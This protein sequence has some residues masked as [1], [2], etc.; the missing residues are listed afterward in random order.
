[1]SPTHVFICPNSS[2]TLPFPTA[3]ESSGDAQS[4]MT[5]QWS[6]SKGRIQN[7]ASDL[8]FVEDPFPN[9]PASGSPTSTGPVLEGH[10]LSRQTYPDF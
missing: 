10:I 8:A 9:N 4:L 1:M 6:L 7:G 2:T 5:S 3:T